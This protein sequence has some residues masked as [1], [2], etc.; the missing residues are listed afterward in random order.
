ME[1]Q[2]RVKLFIEHSSSEWI[3]N[4]VVCLYDRDRLSRD[5]HLGTGITNTY[6]E[7]TFRFTAADFLDLDERLGGS[8]PEL[9]VKVFDSDGECVLSTRAEAVAN[10]VPVLIRVP[11]ERELARRH[12]LIR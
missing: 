5:D 9:Y 11:V 6:G 10:D 2:T 7:A 1:Y 3:A 4:A 8:L 12:R